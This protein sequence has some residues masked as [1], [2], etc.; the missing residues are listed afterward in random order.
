MVHLGNRKVDLLPSFSTIDRDPYPSIIGF[1]DPVSVSRIDPH[2]MMVAVKL[3]TDALDGSTSVYGHAKP[4][5]RKINLILI[6]RRYCAPVVECSP[7]RKVE[8]IT[9]QFPVLPSVI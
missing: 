7:T 1:N 8:V 5:C 3:A 6:V 2:I 4:S 9:Y